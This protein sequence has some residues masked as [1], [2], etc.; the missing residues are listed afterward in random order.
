MAAA[1]AGGGGGSSIGSDSGVSVKT[2]LDRSAE[3][4][5]NRSVKSMTK[6]LTQAKV[7]KMS[8]SQLERIATTIETKRQKEFGD[9]WTKGGISITSAFT[10]ALDMVPQQTT[11]QLRKLVWK[12]RNMS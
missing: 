3:T 7:N 4:A 11:A 1:G 9:K 12:Y 8:R 2:D 6:G 5:Y 10:R